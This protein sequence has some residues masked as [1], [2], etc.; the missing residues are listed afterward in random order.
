MRIARSFPALVRRGCPREAHRLKGARLRLRGRPPL[1]A[2]GINIFGA[3]CALAVKC[4][5]TVVRRK[6]NLFDDKWA[7]SHLLSNK[8]ICHRTTVNGH[9]TTDTT[10]PV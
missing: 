2:K 10:L 3:V 1:L 7:F 9:R 4:P 8:S 6:I 5:L